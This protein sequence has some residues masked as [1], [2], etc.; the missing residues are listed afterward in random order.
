MRKRKPTGGRPLL[1]SLLLRKGTTLDAWV[2]D[3]AFTSIEQVTAAC[4]Q[5]GAE[6][7]PPMAGAIHRLLTARLVEW[8]V[9]KKPNNQNNQTGEAIIEVLRDSSG[10]QPAGMP[11]P[12]RR[13]RPRHEEPKASRH[14]DKTPD[15]PFVQHSDDVVAPLRQD[16]RQDASPEA[17]DAGGDHVVVVDQGS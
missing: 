17:V 5:M 12:R 3:M 10:G 4:R 1:T 11:G 9:V 7:P 8:P 16:D 15:T 2:R 13:T 14:A 6:L